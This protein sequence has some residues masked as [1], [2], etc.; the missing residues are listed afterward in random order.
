VV[1]PEEGD[2]D[3]Q[4]APER[5]RARRVVG[6][7]AVVLLLVLAFVGLAEVGLT[8]HR[9][10]TGSPDAVLTSP[11]TSM[12]PPAAG[13]GHDVLALGDSVPAGAACGC[14]PFP[15]VYGTLLHRRLGVPVAVDNRAVSGLDTAGV[16]AQLRTPGV[17]ESVR[18]ADIVLL[19][20]GANDFGE[21]HDQI[22]G[23]R[24]GRGDTDCVSDELASL[25][26]HLETVLAGIRTLR[27]GQRTSVLVTGYW[28]VFEDGDV[29]RRAFG[30]AGLQASLRVTR[31]VNDVIRSVATAHDARYVDLLDS[32]R[33]SGKDVTAL[34]APDGD[35]PDAAGH[36]Q[37]AR[38]LLDAG[39]PRLS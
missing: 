24:C 18:R 11:R 37:I 5:H 16:V 25:R 28:N 30:E 10:S 9:T 13:G 23:G 36:E 7:S 12:G 38:A 14:Q 27:G 6:R 4:A 34:M 15:E 33:H 19:T 2:T 8:S 26:D 29:A 31:R 20:I 3:A 39:L 22:V 1:A 35:H 21:H 17:D 32:F